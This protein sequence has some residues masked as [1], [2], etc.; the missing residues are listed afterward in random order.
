MPQPPCF[1][2]LIAQGIHKYADMVLLLLIAVLAWWLVGL[3]SRITR[4]TDRIQTTQA[5]ASGAKERGEALLKRLDQIDAR[6]VTID[7]RLYLFSGSGRRG[8]M[9]IQ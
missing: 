1:Q 6:L 5:D 7:N 9:D 2:S 3:D 4:N 8:G